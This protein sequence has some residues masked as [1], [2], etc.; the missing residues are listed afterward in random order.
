MRELLCCDEERRDVK[1]KLVEAKKSVTWL[2][3]VNAN[4]DDDKSSMKFSYE[5]ALL[6]CTKAQCDAK[7]LEEKLE[8]AEDALEKERGRGGTTPR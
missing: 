2:L 1:E 8:K 7:D 3:K 6:V 4:L 5:K